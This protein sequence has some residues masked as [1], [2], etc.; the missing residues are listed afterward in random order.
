VLVK[1]APYL[2]FLVYQILK[3]S[4]RIQIIEPP[5]VKKLLDENQSFVI[6]H[7]HGDELG[8]LHLLK[9]YRAACMVSTSKDGQIMDKAIKLFGGQTSRGSST[10]QGTQALK[11]IIQLAKKG[12]RPGVAVDGPKGPIYQVKSGVFQISRLTALPIYPLVFQADR[13][14]L[15]HKSWN[16]ACLPKPF[17]RVVVTWGVPISALT[18]QDD[19]KEGIWAQKLAQ[20]LHEAKNKAKNHLDDL[21]N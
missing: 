19:P 20:N 10:R 21:K 17:A 14:F 13:N 9:R 16:Q 11:G 2:L 5:E 7:W 12:Y 3:W 6:A 8:I 1:L 4:W 18:K 15:F